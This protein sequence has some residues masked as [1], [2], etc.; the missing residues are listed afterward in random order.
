[1]A[2]VK[3]P[4]AQQA[5]PA[6]TGVNFGDDAFYMGGG[7]NLP[8]GNYALM[9]DIRMHAFTKANGTKGEEYLG[10]MLTAWPLIE[11][12]GE[13][14][15]GEEPLPQFYSM[16]KKAKL[17]FA[18]DPATGKGLIAIPN[19]PAQNAPRLTNWD[20]FRKSLYDAGLPSGIFTNDISVL[21]GIWVHTANVKPPEERKAF[22][23]ATGEAQA[24][25]QRENLVSVVTEILDGGAPWDGGGGLPEGAAEAAAPAPPPKP[26]ARAAVRPAARAAA[27]TA[28]KAPARPVAV[29][30]KTAPAAPAE[31]EG[32]DEEAV[33]EAA[34]TALSTVLGDNPKGLKKLMLRTSAFKE[35]ADN[36]DMAQAVMETHFSDDAAL[37]ALLGPLGFKLSGKN[38]IDV[39][40][41]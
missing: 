40:P 10:I 23:A 8:E 35:M 15:Y 1:M 26:A 20:I 28:A 36:P 4:P 22:G 30:R 21:D 39:V 12:N 37:E 3:R 41:A 34:N 25:D 38:G 13:L 2:P 27:P 14:S 6:P 5:P 16:G 24:E 11:E 18:P 9:F 31:E 7:F 29:A 32:V 17:S 33:V 19:A